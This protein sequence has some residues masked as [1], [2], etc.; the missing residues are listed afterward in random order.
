[1]IIRFLYSGKFSTAI[2]LIAVYSMY[3]ASNTFG[4]AIVRGS[5]SMS[6][7]VSY[8]DVL[9]RMDGEDTTREMFAS[10]QVSLL[11]YKPRK[12]SKEV[13]SEDGVT[14]ASIDIE[15]YSCEFGKM[16]Y[17]LSVNASEKQTIIDVVLT[18]PVGMLRKQSYRYLIAPE[19]GSNTSITISQQMDVLLM[20]RQLELVN[21][22]IA[23]VT[24][25]KACE[26]LHKLTRR[27]T[28]SVYLICIREKPTQ[29]SEKDNS[30]ESDETT[31]EGNTA[32]PPK[33][34]IETATEEK[35]PSESQ[36]T[37]EKAVEVGKPTLR[38]V[39]EGITTSSGTVRIAV[40]KSMA[41]FKAFDARKEED[42]QGEALRKIVVPVKGTG[43][44][45][46][47]F[48]DVPPGQ[49]VIAAFH[50]RD[51]NKKLNASLLGLP[52][53]PYGFSR[54]ARGSLGAPKFEDAIINF[55]D[56]NSVFSFKVK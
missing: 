47:E 46:H 28:D 55:D 6:V 34:A 3:F 38:V 36:P 13:E 27:M 35:Q 43:K 20:Q 44:V 7:P 25:A 30:P 54:D 33:D 40:F 5:Y 18:K 51:G 1:M 8:Q 12:E 48:T 56:K 49:Y 39:V 32:E 42:K 11:E 17:L 37:S 9:S 50:D 16:C 53:E 24:Y 45:N 4:Q 21:R 26:E 10:Q 22:I 2:I 31:Q 41:E 15:G 23:E 19:G 14:K 29:A 52:S